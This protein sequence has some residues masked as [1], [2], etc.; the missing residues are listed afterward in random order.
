MESLKAPGAEGEDMAELVAA[1]TTTD[2]AILDSHSRFVSNDKPSKKRGMQSNQSLHSN[3]HQ[4]Q[5]PH[6]HRHKRGGSFRSPR[7][8]II[9]RRSTPELNPKLNASASSDDE[10][11]D[12][13][14][15]SIH[16]HE[17]EAMDAPLIRVSN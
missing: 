2:S 16:H 3:Q 14:N 1:L 9:P 12:D 7:L 11:D 8:P 5:H 15:H 13:N 4:Q 10:R 17:N 6:P